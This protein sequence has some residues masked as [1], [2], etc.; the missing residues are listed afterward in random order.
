MGY[1]VRFLPQATIDRDQ[2]DLYLEEIAPEKS[3]AFF[4]LLKSKIQALKRNPRMYR[5]YEEVPSYRM[6]GV[7]DYIVFYVV[8]DENKTIEVHRILW[9]G[10]NLPRHLSE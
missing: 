2:I 7:L 9:A 1:R 4:V 5:E 10:M 3:I 6:M 8:K